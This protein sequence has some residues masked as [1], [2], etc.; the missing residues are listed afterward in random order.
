MSIFRR[1]KTQT[2]IGILM[3]S[4]VL[5]PLA[6]IAADNTAVQQI[7][8]AG[9]LERISTLASDEFGGRAPMSE[10]ERLTLNYL[11]QQFKEMGLQP[12]FGDSYRQSVPLVSIA[13]SPDMSLS[14]SDIEGNIH[15][16]AYGSEMM[17]SSPQVLAENGLSR[18]ELVWVG[19][20]IVAPEYDWNDYDGINVKGKTVVIL[21]NDPGYATQNPEL[22]NGNSMT[23]YGRWTYKYEEAMR[24]G[25]DAAL[26]IHET[27]PAGYPWEVVRGGWTG[28]AFYLESADGNLSRVP[29]EGWISGDAATG[30]AVTGL[31][32]MAGFQAIGAIHPPQKRVAVALGDRVASQINPVGKVA[33]GIHFIKFGEV[34]DHVIRQHRQIAGGDHLPFRGPAV[35]CHID[36]VPQAQLIGLGVHPLDKKRLTTR[37]GFGQNHGGIVARLNNNSLQ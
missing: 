11:E 29:V 30:Q 22:F 35:G 26:V 12:M 36:T 10:G 16:Y 3:L 19:Y 7:D 4:L 15:A 23:Y 32:S 2:A 21:V 17:L 33:L 24:Q 34:T 1:S 9:L 31:I 14:I 13:A 28:Q 37:Q 25:A 8:T 5:A 18:S 20:G 27:G 6:T